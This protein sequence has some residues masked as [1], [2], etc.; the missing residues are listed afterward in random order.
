MGIEI[1]KKPAPQFKTRVL[2]VPPPIV[3]GQVG[4][5][6]GAGVVKI[7][8]QIIQAVDQLDRKLTKAEA[9]TQANQAYRQSVVAFDQ[10]IRDLDRDTEW[11]TFEQR[12]EQRAE[13]IYARQAEGISI[14]EGQRE[15]TELFQNERVR[16]LL[17][18]KD[19]RRQKQLGYLQAELQLDVEMGI[20]WAAQTGDENYLKYRV[21]RAVED[22]VV[23]AAEG[24]KFLTAAEDAVDW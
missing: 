7:G 12:F 3:K 23:T 8:K 9:T 5:A 18:T 19:K 17:Q 14:Q 13:E 16:R 1:P 4:A 10:F 6:V 24:K 15:F 11:E 2:P 22:G 20:D 21:E